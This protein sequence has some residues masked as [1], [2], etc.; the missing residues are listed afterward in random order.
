MELEQLI[1]LGGESWEI[2]LSERAF[3]T[4]IIDQLCDTLRLCP[5]PQWSEALRVRFLPNVTERI[6]LLD[7]KLWQRTLH[8]FQDKTATEAECL[9]AASQLLL[10]IW[11]Y[12]FGSINGREESPFSE[13]AV[14]TVRSKS[15]E[16]R[17]A[18]CIRDVA[19]G[20]HSRIDD[21]KA[22]LGS[23]DPDLVRIFRRACWID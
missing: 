7:P 2:A 22:M 4:S 20:D 3:C 12:L 6:T 10:D 23:D 11:L 16:L 17:I 9:N 13:L 19:Y 14:L 15:S 18:H 8:A 5:R 21:L 1:S